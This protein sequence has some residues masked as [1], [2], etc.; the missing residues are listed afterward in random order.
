MAELLDC[1][2]LARWILQEN[3]S[4]VGENEWDER[5][6]KIGNVSENW[7]RRGGGISSRKGGG[8]SREGGKEWR[9]DGDWIREKILKK[10]EKNGNEG[11]NEYESK[12][13]MCGCEKKTEKK[14]DWKRNSMWYDENAWES[15]RVRTLAKWMK[16]SHFFKDKKIYFQEL[17]L[18]PIAMQSPTA[19]LKK[20]ESKYWVNVPRHTDIGRNKKFTLWTPSECDSDTHWRFTL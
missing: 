11:K 1:W 17:W 16:N 14:T 19:Q 6:T 13:V 15:E 5:G 20:N 9:C 2:T 18:K 4:M 8:I 10:I 7:W 12:R 3:V